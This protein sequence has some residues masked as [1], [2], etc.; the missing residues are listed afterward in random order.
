MIDSFENIGQMHD[1]MIKT[2]LKE[3]KKK[4]LL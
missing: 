3:K 4:K 2:S 1:E